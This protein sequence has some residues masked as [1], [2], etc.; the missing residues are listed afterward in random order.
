MKPVSIDV[1]AGLPEAD[2]GSPP[3]PLRVLQWAWL[4]VLLAWLGVISL[5]W[6]AVAFVL[7]FFLRGALGRRVGCAGIAYGYRF[8]WACAR[9]SGLMRLEAE[10][11]D[12]LRDQP[13]G[14]LIAANHPSVLDAL[15]I[16]ARLPRSACIMK[17]SLMRN[18]FL[19][20]AAG[21]AGYVV[22]DSIRTM[23]RTSIDR[24][25]EGCQLVAFPEGTRSPAPGQI[26]PF[27][28]S[29][30]LIAVRAQVPVQTVVIETDSP[31]L[32]KGWPLWKL[33]PIPVRF[34]ARLGQRFEPGDDVE[35]L[36]VRMEE[37]FR[38]ELAR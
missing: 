13:G 19:G 14:L 31:Y 29:I 3:W 15:M 36:S 17:G 16:V 18:P 25:E 20:T 24:L 28:R 10:S 21:F 9:A 11:L 12:V 32:G 34:R 8:Y 7:K 33:P 37:Y 6:N 38:Q 35:Q 27:S 23:V 5:A 26:H 22:N 4:L 2:K 1:D 30:S